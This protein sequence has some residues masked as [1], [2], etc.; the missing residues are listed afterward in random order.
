MFAASNSEISGKGLLSPLT[1]VVMLLVG[2]SGGGA[3]NIMS[4]GSTPKEAS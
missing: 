3:S 2:D 4:E 1:D